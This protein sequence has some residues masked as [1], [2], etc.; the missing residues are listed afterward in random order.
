MWLTFV[1]WLW[2]GGDNVSIQPTDIPPPFTT[3]ARVI[4]D[5]ERDLLNARHAQ[6]HGPAR[7]HPD[8]VTRFDKAVNDYLDEWAWHHAGGPALDFPVD[9][10][11]DETPMV[12]LTGGPLDAPLD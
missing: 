2:R 9:D 10:R 7:R 8:E 6:R 4:E 1:L 3:G 12:T 11:A 5:V